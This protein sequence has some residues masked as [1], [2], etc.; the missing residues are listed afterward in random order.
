MLF[1]NETKLLDHK[2]KIPF[3]RADISSFSSTQE[4]SAHNMDWLI[5]FGHK[6]D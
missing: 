6:Q 5:D 2:R 1:H 3:K 4:L